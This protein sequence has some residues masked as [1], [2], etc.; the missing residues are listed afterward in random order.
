MNVER[1]HGCSKTMRKRSAWRSGSRCGG[2]PPLA[3]TAKSHYLINFPDSNQCNKQ[4]SPPPR[5]LTASRSLPL[6]FALCATRAGPGEL[7]ACLMNMD[8][9]RAEEGEKKKT[10]RNPPPKKHT[11]KQVFAGQTSVFMVLCKGKVK[12]RWAPKSQKLEDGKVPGGKCGH[13][14]DDINRTCTPSLCFLCISLCSLSFY[15]PV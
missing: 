13:L 3:C 11:H 10:K 2:N 8:R 6:H 5:G 14:C 7:L 4:T 12:G 9:C 15:L 1:E